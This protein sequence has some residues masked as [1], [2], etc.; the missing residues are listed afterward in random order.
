MSSKSH[1]SPFYLRQS[2]LVSAD[3]V[4]VINV[5]NSENGAIVITFYVRGKS[6]NVV[7]A[8]TVLEAVQVHF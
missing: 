4:V 5:V 1:V 3:D 8:Q 7:S 6:D 2:T